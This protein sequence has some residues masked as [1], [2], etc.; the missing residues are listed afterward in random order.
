M[1]FLFDQNISHKI[2]DRLPDLCKE[3]TSVKSEGLVNEPDRVIWEFAR[4][5]NFIVVTQ[6]SDFNDLTALHG[7]PP[8]I[9]WIRSGNLRTDEIADLLIKK[10]DA[11]QD[12]LKDDNLGCLEI[13]RLRKK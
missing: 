8:K 7:F 5:N 6:D 11:I 3:S 1:R 13:I 4:R 10:L 2:L 12:F 9:V